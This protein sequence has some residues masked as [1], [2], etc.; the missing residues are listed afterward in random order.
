MDE[1]VSDVVFQKLKGKGSAIE[2]EER[3]GACDLSVED[4]DIVHD[5]LF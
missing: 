4:V 3:R 2:A 1:V 5:I